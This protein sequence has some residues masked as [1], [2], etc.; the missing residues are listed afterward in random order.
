MLEKMAQINALF[1]VSMIFSLIFCILSYIQHKRLISTKTF[2]SFFT[3]SVVLI[4]ELTFINVASIKMMLSKSNILRITS[5][6]VSTIN[7]YTLI[8]WSMENYKRI[9]TKKR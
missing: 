4:L 8:V 2:K 9:F 6:I 1:Y 3:I 5:I 7:I